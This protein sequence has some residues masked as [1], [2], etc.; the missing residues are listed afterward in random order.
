MSDKSAAAALSLY[1]EAYKEAQRHKWI[2]SQ[3]QGR[4]L[5]DN[6]LREWYRVH[7][8]GYC[9]CKRLEHLQGSRCW[10]EFGNDN[11]GQL[12]SLI[13][14]GDPLVEWVLDRYDAGMENLDI[15]TWAYDW[16]LPIHRVVDIL[17]QIDMNRARLDPD[18]L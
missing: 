13:L 8:H 17:M 15:I 11:F 3:K 9:R 18:R 6:A 2:E 5:G 10:R 4:D 1:E 7:W 14:R 16:G 12:Y